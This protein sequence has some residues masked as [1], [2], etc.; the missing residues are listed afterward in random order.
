MDPTLAI[1]IPKGADC[2]C[3]QEADAS[4]PTLASGRAY[5]RLR[6]TN[7]DTSSAYPDSLIM[8]AFQFQ[9]QP[10]VDINTP[11]ITTPND[12]IHNY[13]D[14]SYLE[15]LYQLCRSRF[16]KKNTHFGQRISKGWPYMR[17]CLSERKVLHG[18]I[19]C[20]M[21][22]TPAVSEGRLRIPECLEALPW[23]DI[24]Q[25]S[26]TDQNFRLSIQ[27]EK[28][29]ESS[30]N[31]LTLTSIL[32]SQFVISWKSLFAHRLTDPTHPTHI[33]QLANRVSLSFLGFQSIIA[34]SLC[35]VKEKW[36]AGALYMMLGISCMI[37]SLTLHHSSRGIP[38][39]YLIIFFI[40][41][42]FYIAVL[43]VAVLS[44]LLLLLL[45]VISF[46]ILIYICLFI[47]FLG[48]I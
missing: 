4:A 45:L 48:H 34:S 1:T 5:F 30:T 15:L 41:I 37:L 27:D 33:P 39:S 43:S 46:I 36:F 3:I 21:V 44:V 18:K 47:I 24:A 22:K 20:F 8:V 29:V 9:H 38:L 6:P 31:V 17:Y 23:A 35:I 19:H 32:D 42:G 25:L 11:L 10:P 40:F 13:H 14:Y 16:R 7:M 12:P 2:F 26:H 28:V